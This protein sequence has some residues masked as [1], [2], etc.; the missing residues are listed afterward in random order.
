[1]DCV[2]QINAVDSGRIRGGWS[3]AIAPYPVARF[4]KLQIS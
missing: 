3:R 2:A 4:H 1:V